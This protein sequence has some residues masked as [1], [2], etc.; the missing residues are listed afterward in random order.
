VLVLALAG[1]AYLTRVDRPPAPSRQLQGA[2]QIPAPSSKDQLDIALRF[3]PYLYFDRAEH[4]RPLAI[5]AFLRETWPGGERHEVCPKG[6]ARGC[7]SVASDAEL[8]A[9]IALQ[10]PRQALR[11]S[12]HGRRR[13]GADY[14][15]P[16]L[17]TCFESEI[18]RDCNRGPASV[19]YA[20]V[21]ARARE[22]FVDYWWFY[23]YNDYPWTNPANCYLLTRL[24]H[25]VCG[26]HEGD[27][28][29]MTVVTD[30]PATKV[31]YA[32]FA[33]HKSPIAMF[34]GT[35]GDDGRR[36]FE[37]ADQS[38]EHITVYVAAGTHA[39]YASE[40]RRRGLRRCLESGSIIWE[41][42]HDGDRSWGRNDDHECDRYGG[43]VQLLPRSGPDVPDQ[44]P[45]LYA[46]SWNAW[47]GLWGFCLPRDGTCELGPR[48]PGLQDRYE[49][50]SLYAAPAIPQVDTA[51]P[52]ASPQLVPAIG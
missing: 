21:H 10:Q 5:G 17:V 16:T 23:R 22:L 24:G 20:N 15:S 28:E 11:L 36:T 42:F 43:C 4:W 39:S 31:R 47:P 50:P 33:Q 52:V 35:R 12:I 41:G 48:S 44:E 18:V 3:R 13:N 29:G 51:V 25:D 37:F 30:N 7:G 49:R 6:D 8:V 27:W 19:I 9:S 34:P 1:I 26:D 38:H 46:A 2:G 45:L 32:V 40:C 14:A